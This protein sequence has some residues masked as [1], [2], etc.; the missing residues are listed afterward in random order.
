MN[1][2]Y[3]AAGVDV[4]AGYKAVELIGKHVSRTKTPGVL[5]GI[6]GFA[7]LFALQDLG[8]MKQPVLVSGADGVGTKLQIAKL[9][10][11]HDTVGI[12]AVAMCVND[13]VC[14]GAKPLF[15]LDYIAMGKVVPEKV[16]RIVAGIAEGCILAGCALL[17][18]E[19]AEHPG[20]MPED[21]YDIA[22]FSVGIADRPNI[23]DRAS[24][25]PGDAIIGVASSG[26]H[27]NGF[28]LIRKAL[29]VD[30]PLLEQY[31]AE[32]GKTLG[33]E[34]LVPTKI[35]VKPIMA[36]LER[37]RVRSV[38]H[39][40]GGGFYENI[41]RGISQGSGAVIELTKI[42]T[43]PVFELIQKAGGIP[44]RDMFGTYNMGVGMC[45]ITAPEYADEAVRILKGAGESAGIIGEVRAGAKGVELV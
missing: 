30:R 38:S 15:F 6:G 23:L 37:L 43:P 26:V 21:E 13:V 45:V 28:S 20:V 29:R 3:K 4:A 31:H 44:L 41:P 1:Q 22:G 36:L 25:M 12:D 35:Y 27:S 2:S 14:V 8:G 32:L 10:D 7:G 18:G 5:E 39:I 19:T 34:L 33:E 11:K 9:M 16:E 40:T 42:D 24:V 17:G